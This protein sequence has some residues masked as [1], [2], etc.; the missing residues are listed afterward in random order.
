VKH[1]TKHGASECHRF[2]RCSAT[3]FA[4]VKRVLDFFATLR[5]LSISTALVVLGGATVYYHFQQ[6]ALSKGKRILL[7]LDFNTS[8]VESRP[9]HFFSFRSSEAVTLK[10]ILDTL[11]LAASDS[12][13]VGLV[14]LTGTPRIPLQFGHV[15]ELRDAILS[16]RERTKKP[17]FLF[18]ETFY[19]NL[20]YYLATAFESVSMQPT[21]LLMLMG[22]SS[23]VFFLKQGLEKLGI[24]FKVE[25]R[26]AYKTFPNMFTEKN[27]TPEHRAQQKSLLDSWHAQLCADI[28]TARKMPTTEVVATHLRDGPFL[29]REAHRRGLVDVLEYTDE[30][31]TRVKTLLGNEKVEVLSLKRYLSDPYT[32]SLRRS[33]RDRDS[34]LSTKIALVYATGE[35]LNERNLAGTPMNNVVKALKQISRAPEVKAI[36]VRVNSP[37][38]SALTSDAIWRWVRVNQDLGK[39]VYFSFANVAASGGYY[40]ATAADRILAQPGTITGSIGVFGHWPVAKKFLEEKLGITTDYV[41]TSDNAFFKS[42]LHELTP[43]QQTALARIVDQIY[44][45]FKER[46]AHG[47]RMDMERVESLAQGRVY[48]GQQA[49]DLGLVDQLGGLSAALE[50]AQKEVGPARVCVFPK[51]KYRLQEMLELFRGSFTYSSPMEQLADMMVTHLFARPISPLLY[52]A[53]L[54]LWHEQLLWTTP[55]PLLLS[56]QSDIFFPFGRQSLK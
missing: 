16:W 36:V 48:T 33:R 54:A 45:E 8:I 38:G 9:R 7:K 35:I 3:M 23:E 56:S 15:Q 12:R 55:L 39:K 14:G 21:G 32:R 13:V 11:N 26:G 41:A 25:K 31:F 20:S 52:P 49:L 18:A 51:R 1:A 2:S 24:D 53:A 29:G 22:L 17:S 4:K 27:F 42:P 46:V 30:F 5:R 40:I 19:D 44:A 37:G 34:S 6:R 28:A 47:R 50:L 10:E 43:T